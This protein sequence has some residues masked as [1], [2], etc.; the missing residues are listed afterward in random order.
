MS[1]T[2]VPVRTADELCKRLDDAF[3]DAGFELGER[4]VDVTIRTASG[5]TVEKIAPPLFNEDQAERLCRIVE[6]VHR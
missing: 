6:G 5:D 2:P 3:R 1:S 4:S